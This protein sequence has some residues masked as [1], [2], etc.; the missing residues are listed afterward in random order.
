ML[1]Q[2][3]VKIL[4]ISQADRS[5]KINNYQEDVNNK[6][7]LIWQNP[8]PTEYT[9]LFKGTFDFTHIDHVL[10]IGKKFS[11]SKN[12]YLSHKIYYLIITFQY[13]NK[14]TANNSNDIP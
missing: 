11:I 6:I 12:E 7:S 10:I 1:N 3:I 8:V 14:N 13:F 4:N 5:S 2:Y 9:Q